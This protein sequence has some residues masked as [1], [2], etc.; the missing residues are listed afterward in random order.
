M[1]STFVYAFKYKLI[2]YRILCRFLNFV[3]LQGIKILC[4][5]DVIYQSSTMEKPERSKDVFEHSKK[6]TEQGHVLL[7]RSNLDLQAGTL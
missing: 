7:W 5:V 4:K 3:A 2:I 6:D 1:K